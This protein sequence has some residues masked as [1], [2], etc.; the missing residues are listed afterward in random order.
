MKREFSSDDIWVRHAQRAGAVLVESLQLLDEP[1]EYSEY[2]ACRT[3]FWGKLLLRRATILLERAAT[4]TYSFGVLGAG[5][6]E[7][8]EYLKDIRA[9]YIDCAE[10]VKDAEQGGS[11]E[12]I[13]IAI[14]RLPS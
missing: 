2:M 14:Q 6:E 7:D 8:G 5:C 13:R 9:E 10:D 12:L 4:T 11:I 3:H 1:D